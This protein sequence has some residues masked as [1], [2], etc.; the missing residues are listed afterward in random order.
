MRPRQRGGVVERCALGR[1]CDGTCHPGFRSP[2]AN[3]T[4]GF[5]SSG[6]SGRTRQAALAWN[7]ALFHF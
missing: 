6:P 1:V 4:L 3:C 7:V 2:S 5:H